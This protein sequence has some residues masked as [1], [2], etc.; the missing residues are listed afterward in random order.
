MTLQDFLRTLRARWVYITVV[1]LLGLLGAVGLSLL[2]TPLYQA[3]T[4]LFVSTTSG[5]T[6]SDM[7]Q[8]NRLSQERVVSYA[9][10]LTGQTLAQRTVDKLGL[11]IS[12]SE[13]QENIKAGVKPD[14]VLIDVHVMDESPVRARDIANTLSEEFVGL[15]RELETPPD[16]GARADARVVVEQRASIPESPVVPKTTRNIA[17]GLGLGLLVG[18]GTAMLRDALDNTVKSRETL[19]E[20]TGVGLVGSIPL[21]KERRSEA[22]I[23]FESDNSAIAEAF[24]KLRTNLQFLAVDNPPRVIVLTSSMPSEGKSTTAINIALALAEGDNNV[25]L[26]DG[27]M[28]RPA[29]AKYL[30]LVGPVGFSTVLSGRASLD[31]A[32]QKTRFAGLTVLTSGTTPPNPS[33]LLGSQSARKLLADLRSRFD[34][35]IV[36]STPLLA[37]TDAA[38]LA[39]GSDAVLIMTR[40]G[41][42]KRDQLTHAVGSLESV[43]APLL[44]AVLTM[45]PLRGRSTYSYNYSYYGNDAPQRASR[46]PRTPADT[47]ASNRGAVQRPVSDH[48]VSRPSDS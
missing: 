24:R 46:R 18:V 47:D 22:A 29:L 44:G 45:T 6:L 31:D 16:S 21:D 9:Q 11:D 7:Y 10:L 25:V 32:L 34:Y 36:D 48:E 43:G 8:G 41:V 14:T 28:R 17:A 27:D 2:T 33:E 42:T 12:A 30:D 37:V 5:A 39:A 19:E 13:L 35:V 38:I 26:V 23:E 20:I 1:A 4:R 3:S 40:F 15:V